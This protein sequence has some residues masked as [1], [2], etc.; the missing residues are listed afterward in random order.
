MVTILD[1][2][3]LAGVSA[4]SVSRVFRQHPTVT[5][6]TASA[7]RKAAEKLGYVHPSERR[8]TPHGL[9]VSLRRVAIVTLGMA[10]SL[11][12]I[13]VVAELLEGAADEARRRDLEVLLCDV[14][15]L[16]AVPAVLRDRAADG[17]LLK[18]GLQGTAEEWQ[19]PAVRAA[20]SFPHVWLTGRPGGCTGDM[21][22]SDDAAAG[23][24]AAEYLVARG[25]RHLAF[26]SA[27]SDHR[28]FL[29]R[30]M[31]FCWRARQLQAKV[32]SFLGEPGSARVPIAPVSEVESV[33]RLLDRLL[34]Q[35]PRP[36]AVFV[37]ADNMAALLY[38]AIAERGL[39]VGRDLSVISCNNER[40]VREGLHPDLA[41]IDIHA[42]ETGAR[43]VDQ[44]YWR[45]ARPD[46]PRETT[47]TITPSLVEGSSVKPL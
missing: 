25:H 14:P 16:S 33:G 44:L 45:A 29:D 36:T 21:V 40:L 32:V 17:L 3:R 22:G 39:R 9:P 18:A 12:R 6:E 1:V 30:E 13:P 34:R 35:K 26:L 43:G 8:R 15:D 11:S 4:G 7:V 38:R 46:D 2:A 24:L 28:L 10:H 19:A 5:P 27:K 31:G 20:T 37:P 23:R 41:T 47:V 42:R